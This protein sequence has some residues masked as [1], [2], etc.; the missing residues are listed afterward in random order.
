MLLKKS[1]DNNRKV[2][3]GLDCN[4]IGKLLVPSPPSLIQVVLVVDVIRA[5]QHWLE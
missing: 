3:I 4:Y 1:F 5:E 2:S